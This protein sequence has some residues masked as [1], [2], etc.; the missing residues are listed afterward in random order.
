MGMCGVEYNSS[1]LNGGIKRSY[2]VVLQY[3]RHR[4]DVTGWASQPVWTV[5]KR[6]C[7]ALPVIEPVPRT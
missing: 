7:L 4:L 3:R 2:S 6:T 5:E 1:F